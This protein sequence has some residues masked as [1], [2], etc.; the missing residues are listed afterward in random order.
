MDSGP[1]ADLISGSTNLKVKAYPDQVRPAGPGGPGPGPGPLEGGTV[2]QPEAQA[3]WQVT[4]AG[5]GT[6]TVLYY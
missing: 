6:V 3:H 1:G 4:Q 2:T 5:P